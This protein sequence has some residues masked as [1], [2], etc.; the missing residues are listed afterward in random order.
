MNAKALSVMHYQDDINTEHNIKSIGRAAVSQ[1]T[2]HLT[3]NGQT[4]VQIR[5]AHIFDITIPIEVGNFLL[6][7]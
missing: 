2:K 4:P 5:K 7:S 1:W 3:R 6:N